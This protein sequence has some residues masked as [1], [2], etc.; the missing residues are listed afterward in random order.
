MHISPQTRFRVQSKPPLSVVLERSAG[1]RLVLL[2][3]ERGRESHHYYL[4]E[5]PSDWGQAFRLE[6]FATQGGQSYDV[7]V[8]EGYGHCGCMGYEAHGHCKH[9]TALRQLVERGEL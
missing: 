2:H 8:D 9:V 3:L 4:S 1:C 7:L 6:K 5:I